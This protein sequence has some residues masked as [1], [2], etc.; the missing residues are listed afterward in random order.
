MGRGRYPFSAESSSGQFVLSGLGKGMRRGLSSAGEWVLLIITK[1]KQ[2][3][4][5]YPVGEKQDTGLAGLARQDKAG[6]GRTRQDK[7]RQG[8]TRHDKADRTRQDTC[9]DELA[10]DCKHKEI[11]K[12]ENEEGNEENTGGAN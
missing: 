10:R 12:G 8:T 1:N 2:Y 5:N 6:Q 4:K 3:N 11:I 7:A 9:D